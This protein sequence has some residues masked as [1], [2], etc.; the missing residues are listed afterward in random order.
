MRPSLIRI[1]LVA[2]LVRFMLEP[3]IWPLAI[4]VAV[5]IAAELLSPMIPRRDDS[6]K[7]DVARL[8][9]QVSELSDSVSKLSL[10]AGFSTSPFASRG[11]VE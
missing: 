3:F 4:A 9:D 2:L 10:K 8:K 7:M 1:V 5:A 11:R 6:L